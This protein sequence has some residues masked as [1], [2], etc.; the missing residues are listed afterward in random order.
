MNQKGEV[1]LFSCCLILAFM[2]VLLLS[3]IKLNHSFSLMKKRTHLFLCVK[4]TKG[5]LHEFMLFMGRTNWG[6][7]NLNRASL[8]MAFIPGLQGAALDAQKAKKYLQYIQEGRLLLYLKTLADLKRKSCP[9]DP[10]MLLTPFELGERLLKRDSEG[11]AKLRRKEWDYYFLQRPYLLSIR[12]DARKYSRIN[13]R[14]S[15]ETAE[16]GV[17]S[18]SLLS[19]LY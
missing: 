4:E 2:S 18:L 17:K 19:S 13:P 11:A 5:E 14:M 12:V 1:T 3:A 16:K 6:I 9:L 7:N 10:R 15:Y 8:I